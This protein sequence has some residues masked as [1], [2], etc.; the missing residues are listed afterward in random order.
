MSYIEQPPTATSRVQAKILKLV[1]SVIFTIKKIGSAFFWLIEWFSISALLNCIQ[2]L[3]I[4]FFVPVVPYNVALF[5]YWQ[6]IS[7]MK[8]KKKGTANGACDNGI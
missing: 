7:T 6:M 5:Y 3:G 8:Q 4:G 1:I 2:T